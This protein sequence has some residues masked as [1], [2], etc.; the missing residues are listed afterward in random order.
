MSNDSATDNFDTMT[1]TPIL[2]AGAGAIGSILGGMLHDAGHDVTMLGRRAH[3]DAIARGGLRISGLLGERTVMGMKLADDP[4][5]LAGRFG[6]ILCAVKSY[7]TESIADA[8]A[9]RLNSDG[10]IVSMQNGLGNIE[11]L[12]ERFGTRR[13]LGAR[14]IF[15]AEIPAP[16]S[17]HVTVFA[18]PVA[19]GPAPAINREDS[20][21][22][23]ER[24]RAIAAMLDAAGVP[25]AGAGDIT[26]VIWTK[27]LYN[28]ALNPLGAILRLHYGALA[29]DAD[30]RAIMERAIDEAFA[31]ARAVGVALPFAN[32]DE[33]RKVF[34]EQLI[35]PTFDH[36]PTMWH[37]LHVRGRT[38]I[39]AL[40]GR[41]VELADAFGLEAETNRML[42]RL[43]RAA[44]R[45][46]EKKESR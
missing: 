4:A 29:A 3:L 2:I 35:P 44:E 14:V 17:A 43:I 16:G 15:G 45:V 7:D 23:A 5:R 32:A 24:A 39:G 1:D 22:L 12:I 25:A 26:P 28:I 8:L 10:V 6:L 33:Y 9:G 27:L 38:E 34:Y 20:P 41:I 37:D 18:Q 19:I 40:N 36:R 46:T 21:A 30:V 42:T 13:V 31:V 11:S